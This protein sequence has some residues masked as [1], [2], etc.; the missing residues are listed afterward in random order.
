[1]CLDAGVQRAGGQRRG[2]TCP[3]APR[4]A[5]EAPARSLRFSSSKGELSRLSIFVAAA[6]DCISSRWIGI[7]D[8]RLA[9]D[10]PRGL[11]PG[12]ISR[13]GQKGML[14]YRQPVRSEIEVSRAL[15][16]EN[17]AVSQRVPAHLDIPNGDDATFPPETP[18][19]RPFSFSV[20]VGQT[21]RQAHGSSAPAGL[22]PCEATRHDDAYLVI[23][24][25][26][27]ADE[28]LDHS[29]CVSSAD[30]V[31]RIGRR[32]CAIYQRRRTAAREARGEREYVA[33]HE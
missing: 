13:W 18:I 20:T 12:R 31:E 15:Q 11:V 2:A 29:T 23:V 21:C 25:V 19:A 9:V 27:R 16:D 17:E 22:K 30:G 28:I 24:D 6:S 3:R 33:G 1:V 10:R 14:L 4:A 8:V 32:R 5:S 7:E 26:G